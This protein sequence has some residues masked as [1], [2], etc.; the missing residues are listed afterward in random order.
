M[1]NKYT[2][3]QLTWGM[4]KRL[5]DLK[6]DLRFSSIEAVIE[7]LLKIRKVIFMIEREGANREIPGT[8]LYDKLIQGW[9][10]KSYKIKE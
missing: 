9:K 5:I 3:A 1:G 2:S 4:R 6:N 10:I 7:N 8:Q